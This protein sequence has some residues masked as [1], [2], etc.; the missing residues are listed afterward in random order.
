VNWEIG[1]FLVLGGVVLG[2]VLAIIAGLAIDIYVH[3]WRNSR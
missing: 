2:V 1:A 3:G